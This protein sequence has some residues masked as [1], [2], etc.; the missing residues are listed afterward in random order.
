[1][2]EHVTLQSTGLEALLSRRALLKRGAGAA[3]IATL[4]GNALPTEAPAAPA[5]T[6][7]DSTDL[8]PR[9]AIQ[10][11]LDAM[12]R[13]PLV[14]I[15]ERHF[16]QEWHDYITALLFHPS[17]A[18]KV[19]HIAV[20]FGN[21]QF[22]DVADR[23][24]LGD[25]PVA[26]DELAQIWRYLGWDAPVYEQ[27]FR[28]VRAVNWMQPPSRRVRVLL[29]NPPYDASKVRSSNDAGFRQWWNET[30]DAYFAAI[31]EQEVLR[32]GGR[33]LLI[34]GSGH[35]LRGIHRDGDGAH[36]DAGAMLAQQ[37]PGKL[38]VVDNL[39]LPSGPQKDAAGTRL[40][41]AVAHWPRP[42]IALLRG[43]WL[44]ALTQMVDDTWINWG[45]Q[46]AINAAAARY[47]AQADAIL[48]L[49][50]A[51]ALSASQADP[52]IF[53]WGA[54]PAQLRRLNPIVSQIDR[55]QEDLIAESLHW[56]TAGPGWFSLFS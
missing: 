19:T 36:L 26:R 13:F 50:P 20:E 33:A 21:A 43:T 42:S 40:Q 56:A 6:A 2:A 34:A 32:K 55:Q 37:H 10:T 30:I 22:Q 49:G 15:A 29:G 45:A 47:E 5:G 51:E 8:T 25:K 48:Y 11:V 14:A 38:F 54:Y 46:R 52:A 12:D 31:V 44:G 1:M 24:I 39:V 28:T 53:H 4:A 7:A 23:F 3:A 9:N 41:A 27:F 17:F 16:L 18:G 35:V